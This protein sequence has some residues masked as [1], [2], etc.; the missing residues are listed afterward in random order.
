M[1]EILQLVESESWSCG[2]IPIEEACTKINDSGELVP[3]FI[4]KHLLRCYGTQF[5]DENG[6][7]YCRLDEQKVRFSLV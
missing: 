5:C 6:T 4:V 7:A 3:S 1:G 2:Q